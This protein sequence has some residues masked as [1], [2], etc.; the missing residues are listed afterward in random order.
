MNVSTRLNLGLLFA[1]VPL[2]LY[3]L[4]AGYAKIFK[5]GIANFVD[6]GMKNLPAFLPPTLG[7][8]YLYALPFVECLVGLMVILGFFGRVGALIKALILISILMAMGVTDQ[9]KPF[10]S[11]VILLGL[12]LLLALVGPGG[13]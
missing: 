6:F 1:R 11:N 9:G 2:G 13:I 12:A 7:K 10:H 5:T 3:F 8:A 4:L